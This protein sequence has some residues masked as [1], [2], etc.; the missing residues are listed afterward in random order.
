MAVIPKGCI[1][2]A[3][4]LETDGYTFVSCVTTPGF[5]YAGFRIVGRDEIRQRFPNLYEEIKK[6]AAE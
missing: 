4:N 1:F 5:E 3:E 6:L 2:G